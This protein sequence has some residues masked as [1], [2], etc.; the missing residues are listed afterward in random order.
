M[1]PVRSYSVRM[2]RRNRETEASFRKSLSRRRGAPAANDSNENT[3]ADSPLTPVRRTFVARTGPLRSS[4]R[5]AA[6]SVGSPVRTAAG[7]GGGKAGISP[8]PGVRQCLRSDT[9]GGAGSTARH[10]SCRSA[11]SVRDSTVSY[12]RQAGV[13]ELVEDGLMENV[14]EGLFVVNPDDSAKLG[15]AGVSME[16]FVKSKGDVL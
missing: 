1:L 13:D 12:G 7:G 15:S 2:K 3:P 4:V 8:A 16:L 9:T 11:H 6:S 5:S 10:G 14:V